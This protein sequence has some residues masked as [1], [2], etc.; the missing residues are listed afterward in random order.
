[1]VTSYNLCGYTFS[2]YWTVFVLGILGMLLMNLFRGRKDSMHMA[3]SAVYTL[4]VV[5]VSFAGA[6][7][8][9]YIENPVRLIQGRVTM[10]GVSFFGSVY[11]VPVVMYF[12]CK[13]T[14]HSYYKIMDFLSPS[15]M[16]MLAV[17]RIGCMISD[18]CGGISTYFMGVYFDKFPTQ[19]TECVMDIIIMIGLLLYEK[20][21]KNEG[22]LY[23]F[24]M[25]YYGIIR[26]FIEFLRDTPKD[27]LYFSHGQWFSVISIVI[28]GYML[29]RLG[30]LARKEKR[31]QR[32]RY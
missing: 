21:W 30:K 14:K 23:Y 7:L 6:K 10:G 8:L 32:R 31:M 13:K 19:I 1:M 24:I 27:W 20:F 15:L 16:L 11:L 25:V 26:F 2:I 4:V 12:V 18:C 22:R 17:L 3:T 28:G 9:Y 5:I 29:H